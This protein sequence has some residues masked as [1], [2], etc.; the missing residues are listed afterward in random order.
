MLLHYTLKEK[1]N[2]L[3]QDGVYTQK[4]LAIWFGNET[5]GI[6]YIAVQKC[7]SCVQIN[8]FGIVESMNLSV[9]IGIVL[10][11]ITSQRRDFKNMKLKL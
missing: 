10:H 11:E 4:K 6:T 3:L 5:H 2:Y 9:S 7:N 1:T 8:Q